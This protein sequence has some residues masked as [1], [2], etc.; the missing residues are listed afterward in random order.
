MKV[1]APHPATDP[2]RELAV[3]AARAAD[4]K[5]A[6]DVVVLDV[7][8]VIGIWEHFV[9]AS[10][11]SERQVKAVVDRVEEAVRESTGR[12]PI[13][14]EGRGA[15]RWVVLDFGDV[16]VHVFLTSERDYYRLDKLYGDVPRTKWTAEQSR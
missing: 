11:A 9:V 10:A 2:S 14:D 15:R 1:P 16:A 4:E 6:T 12:S 5:L 3:L 7:G 13:A 8:D